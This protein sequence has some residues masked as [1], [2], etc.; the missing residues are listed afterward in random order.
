[1]YIPNDAVA[2]EVEYRR[3]RLT[4][5]YRAGRWTKR[6]DLRDGMP[7]EHIE[8]ATAVAHDLDC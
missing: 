8:L 3:E 2:A 6:K 5:S 4:R 1:M 7:D